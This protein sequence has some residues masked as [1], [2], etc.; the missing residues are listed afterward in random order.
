MIFTDAGQPV[1]ML[2]TFQDITGRKQVE[3]A[4]QRSGDFLGK[5]FDHASEGISVCQACDVFPYVRFTL[6]NGR[7]TEMTG[8]TMEEINDLGWYQSMYPDPEYQARAIA[9]MERMRDGDH[10]TGEEWEVTTRAGEKRTFSISTS[11]IVTADGSAAVVGLMHD[12]TER[13][14]TAEALIQAAEFRGRLMDQASEGIVLWRQ[15]LTGEPEFISWNPRMQEITGYSQEEINRLGW[16]K[17]IYAGEAERSKARDTMQMVLAGHLNRGVDFEIVT[18]QGEVRH[19]H[20][21]SSLVTGAQREQCVL[22]VV[23]DI[24]ESKRQQALLEASRKRFSTLFDFSSDAIFILDI[25]GKFIDVNKTAYTRLGYSKK[26]MLAMHVAD[27]VPPEFAAIAPARMERVVQN[28][29]AVFESAHYRADG[30]AMPVEIN[31]RLIDLDGQQVI[32]SVIRDISERKE[33][34]EQLRQSQKM[35]AIGTLVGGIAHDFN[36]MLAAMQGNIYL[37]KMEVEPRSMASERLNNIEKLGE[38]A[39][40]MVQQ[41]LTFARKDAVSRRNLVLNSFIKEAYKL[42]GAAIPENID[43]Q[44]VVCDELL[45]IHGDATQLQQVLMNLLNNA[46]DAVAAVVRPEIRCALTYYQADR[47]FAER[48]PELSADHFARISVT[49]NGHGIA[50]DALTKIFEPFYTT[51]EVG[52]GTGLGLA[53]LYGAVQNH[54]GVV[55]V[56]SRPGRTSF[57]IYLP[58]SEGSESAGEADVSACGGGHSETILLVDDEASVLETTCEVLESLGYRVLSAGNG[59]DALA[60]FMAHAEE[61]DLVISDVIMPKM[62]GVELLHSVRKYNEQLPVMLVTGYDRDHV[63]GAGMPGNHCQILNKPFNFDVLSRTIQ[64]LVRHR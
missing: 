54:G 39:A 8:Y 43:H 32:M 33:F 4:L 11:T 14:Q 49:D 9:R 45:I 19:V 18:R 50:P 28:G 46:V 2:G 60:L 34:E 3:M 37:A 31:A 26:E 41:L 53:M 52:K 25:T 58:L 12:V 36:N 6:W 27:L 57:D 7:M 63:I 15:R 55:E 1:R 23:Q 59:E 42:V 20:I 47:E 16:L 30:T 61:V 56:E 62:G 51:K 48:H 21:S 13:K 24:T 44:S 10:L 64:S 17:T 22:A 38:R 29:Y 40:E 5:I 35:E